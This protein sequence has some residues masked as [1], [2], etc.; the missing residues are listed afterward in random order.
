MAGEGYDCM[1]HTQHPAVLLWGP[2]LQALLI[3]LLHVQLY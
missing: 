1:S 3:L 2:R